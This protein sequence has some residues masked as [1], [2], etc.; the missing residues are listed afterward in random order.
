MLGAFVIAA[1]LRLEQAGSCGA[2]ASPGVAL[3]S[4]RAVR[5]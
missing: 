4:A 1:I 3:I 2:M 5:V